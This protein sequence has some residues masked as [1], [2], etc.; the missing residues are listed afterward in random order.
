MASLGGFVPPPKK[1]RKEVRVSFLV[2][3]NSPTRLPQEM[4]KSTSAYALCE[5]LRRPGR[6]GGDFEASGRQR[7]PEAKSDRWEVRWFLL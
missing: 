1:K 3:P 7:G 5:G 4:R 2:S 6:C